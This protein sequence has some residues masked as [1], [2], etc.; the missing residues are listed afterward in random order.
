MA[1][2]AWDDEP[3]SARLEENLERVRVGIVSASIN[4]RA[5]PTVEL[6]LE[7]HR[8]MYE[9]VD[10]PDDAYRGA[11]RGSAHPAL[12]NYEVTV[13]GLAVTRAADITAS[14]SNF[15]SSLH[16]RVV[17]MDDLDA[18][19]DP[20]IL[21]ADFV[22]AAIDAAAWLHGEWIRIHP[23]ANGNGRMARMWV[24][25]ICSRYRLP[26]LLPLR[27]RPDMGYGP[28]TMMSMLGDHRIF[29]QYLLVQYN[30]V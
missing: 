25:W 11:F 26:Q 12:R 3:T 17:T 10:V 18:Q 21:E 19:A 8:Q 30:Q 7:W 24:L 9:G 5:M 14:V 20:E 1:G 2:R 13:G 6:V 23:F 28:A 27:P 16:D 22:E 15:M 29:Y 4:S